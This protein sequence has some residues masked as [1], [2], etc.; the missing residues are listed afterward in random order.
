MYCCFVE[1]K[2]S[3]KFTKNISKTRVGNSDF[4]KVADLQVSG[5]LISVSFL[6]DAY[7]YCEPQEREHLLLATFV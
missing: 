7:G 2:N 6:D 1:K 3:L 4:I 5:E